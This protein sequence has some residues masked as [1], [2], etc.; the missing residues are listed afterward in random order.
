MI[1]VNGSYLSRKA[2]CYQ[3]ESETQ[4][5]ARDVCG[6]PDCVKGVVTAR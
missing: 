3:V 2:S 5:P 1:L 6:R 4:R